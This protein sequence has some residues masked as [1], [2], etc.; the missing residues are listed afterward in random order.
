MFDDDFHV[1]GIHHSYIGL[2]DP[3][4]EERNFRNQGSS[5]IAA[6]EVIRAQKPK[7]A[8]RLTLQV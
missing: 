7:L 2:K 3:D 8:A 1:V 5:M 4:P 6:L